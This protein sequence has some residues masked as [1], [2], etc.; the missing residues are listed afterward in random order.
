MLEVVYN[1][2]SVEEVHSRCEPVPIEGF[3]KSQPASSTRYICDSDDLLEGNDL[4][5][6]DDGNDVDV[7]HKHGSEEDAYHHECP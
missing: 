2:L 4:Y 1:T 7:S 6:S 5:A 3:C